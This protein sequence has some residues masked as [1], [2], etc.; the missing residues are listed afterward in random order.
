MEKY[1][2]SSWRIGGFI[3]GDKWLSFWRHVALSE[4]NIHPVYLH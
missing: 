4:K 2:L 3:F 1:W